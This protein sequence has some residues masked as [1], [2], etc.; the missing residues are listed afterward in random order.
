MEGK[1]SLC[2]RVRT[3]VLTFTDLIY[4][5]KYFITPFDLWL[6]VNKFEIP[7]FVLEIIE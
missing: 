6:L 5:E 3:G 7:L 2:E 4:S 1:K